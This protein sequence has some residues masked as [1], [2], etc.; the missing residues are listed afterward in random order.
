[1]KKQLLIVLAIVMFL[2]G[3][4]CSVNAITFSDGFEAQSFDPFWTDIY[5]SNGTVELSSTI[6][7]SGTQSAKFTETAYGQKDVW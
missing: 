7:H 2:I 1:M 6:S 3:T 5:Q 4:V